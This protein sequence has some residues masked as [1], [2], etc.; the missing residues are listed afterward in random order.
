M[1]RTVL[2]AM[3]VCKGDCM[4]CPECYIDGKCAAADPPQIAALA[5]RLADA[6]AY[7]ADDG[8]WTFVMTHEYGIVSAMPDGSSIARALLAE[9]EGSHED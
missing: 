9:L 3:A 6:L 1:T 4:A 5:L 2:E 7:Y 8:N